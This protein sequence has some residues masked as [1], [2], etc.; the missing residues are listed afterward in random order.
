[1]PRLGDAEGD[2]F[3]GWTRSR[4][5]LQRLLDV[6]TGAHSSPLHIVG[7]PASS[8][9]RGLIPEDWLSIDE[10]V[11]CQELVDSF[12]N[13]VALAAPG[14]LLELF[15]GGIVVLADPSA[16]GELDI[17]GEKHLALDT[18]DGHSQDVLV[19]AFRRAAR[20]RTRISM[21]TNVASWAAPSSP[22]VNWPCSSLAGLGVRLGRLTLSI[23]RFSQSSARSTL[24]AA[25][26]GW[27]GT[28][29]L[30]AHR[31][32]PSRV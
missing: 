19:E 29:V 26:R 17:V 14:G 1:M 10:M 8:L 9:G 16:D 22:V 3:P 20:S 31:M 24:R 13:E 15:E 30:P 32:T 27:P 4:S 5:G 18:L 12:T 21:L 2:P 7:V 6:A 23:S 25:R 28:C 11:A